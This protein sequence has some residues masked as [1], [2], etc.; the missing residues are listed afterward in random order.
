MDLRRASAALLI[1]VAAW[2]LWQ[3]LFPV[4][5]LTQRGSGLSDALLNP[6]SGIWRIG[7]AATA[8]LGGVLGVLRAPG[9]AFLAGA[10]TVLFVILAAL[11][12]QVGN[13]SDMWVDEAVAATALAALSASL[14]F[15][16]RRA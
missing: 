2:L 8:L 16:K 4:I 3:G 5:L 9:A 7:A 1:L 11:L 12:F 15:I 13:G 14:I 10:G 6:P